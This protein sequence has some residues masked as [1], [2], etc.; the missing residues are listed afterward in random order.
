VSAVQLLMMIVDAAHKEELE[1]VLRRSGVG[2]YTELAR[3]VGLGASGPRLGSAPFPRTSAVI[4][5]LV[6]PELAARLRA[7]IAEHCRACGEHVR[8][9]AWPV[10]DLMAGGEG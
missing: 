3:A 5:T 10:E 2:G 4:L 9:V 1:V 6:E 7:E 8:L